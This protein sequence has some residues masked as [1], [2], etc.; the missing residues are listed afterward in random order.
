MKK[1]KYQVQTTGMSGGWINIG[2]GRG[3]PRFFKT[4]KTASEFVI[5]WK[6]DISPLR[7][8]KRGKC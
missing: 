8:V 4:K 5:K 6:K 7:I 1:C 3:F 2:K